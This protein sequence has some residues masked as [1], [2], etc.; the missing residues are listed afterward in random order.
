MFPTTNI[1]AAKLKQEF[2]KIRDSGT[3]GGA[4][5]LG[6]LAGLALACCSSHDDATA[7]VAIALFAICQ[8]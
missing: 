4:E 3:L 7:T 1:A 6:N 5:V 8:G 2:V